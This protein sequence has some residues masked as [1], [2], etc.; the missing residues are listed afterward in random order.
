VDLTIGNETPPS[1]PEPGTLALMGFG[2][3]LAGLARIRR[4]A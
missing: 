4:Q 1:V 3:M 2:V